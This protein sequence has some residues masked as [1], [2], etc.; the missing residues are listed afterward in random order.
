MVLCGGVSGGAVGEED[1]VGGVDGESLGV[2]VDGGLV[3]L[4]CHGGIAL[5]L[6]SLGLLLLGVG[7][8]TACGSTAGGGGGARGARA[9]PELLVDGVDLEQVLGA[10]GGLDGGGVGGVNLE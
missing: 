6:E 5:A 7:G 3:V 8:S 1:G 4:L 10:G 9:G 2:E